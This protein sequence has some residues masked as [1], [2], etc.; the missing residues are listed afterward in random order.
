MAAHGIGVDGN[1]NHRKGNRHAHLGDMGVSGEVGA[2]KEAI[3]RDEK[4]E[5]KA[6]TLEF[7]EQP[8]EVSKLGN[9]PA[10]KVNYEAKTLDGNLG[11]FAFN[12]FLDPVRVMP[13]FRNHV[14]DANHANGMII[15]LRGNRGGLAGMTMGM[16]KPFVTEM[17]TLGVMSMK[18]AELKF[19]D[20]EEDE[21][22]V[23]IAQNNAAYIS[24]RY[25]LADSG[26]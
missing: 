25:R 26:E 2:E 20:S 13:A 17:A 18:G 5:S 6:V 7:I 3:F 10:T 8:G 24:E 16:A 23:E 12:F 9:L 11:Y 1:P 15:D 19:D 22:L 21:L 14:R 4:G